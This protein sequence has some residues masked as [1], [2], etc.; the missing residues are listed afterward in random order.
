[1]NHI[2]SLIAYDAPLEKVLRLLCMISLTEGGIR[3]KQYKHFKQ[4]VIQNYGF[5]H[6][7]TLHNL[8]K[9]GLLTKHGNQKS[10]WDRIKKA[11]SLV[12]EDIN[13]DAP[14]DAC[15]VHAGMAPLVARLVEKGLKG[16]WDRMA[17]NMDKYLP[18]KT[19]R[20]KQTKK[21]PDPKTKKQ[22]HLV[23]LIGG[24]TRAEVSA[25]RFIGKKLKKE[26]V[27]CTSQMLNGNS[28]MK[29]LSQ[30]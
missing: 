14:T 3:D 21:I 16:E 24:V 6:L 28:L 8:D 11:F 10:N 5:Q 13:M 30:E 29:I 1:M 9:M 4:E 18:G 22:F 27:V 20:S 7:V 25:I 19:I 15:Y 17:D 12:Q 26:I 2:D 23:Y